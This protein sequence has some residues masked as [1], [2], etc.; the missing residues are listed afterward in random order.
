MVKNLPAMQEA[1]VWSLVRK[2]LWRREWLPTPVFLPGE[3]HGQR[4]LAGYSPWGCK[5]LDMAERLTLKPLTLTDGILAIHSFRKIYW[6]HCVPDTVLNTCKIWTKQCPSPQGAYNL[7]EKTNNKQTNKVMSAGEQKNKAEKRNV[8]KQEQELF[9]MSLLSEKTTTKKRPEWSERVG[10]AATRKKNP[11]ICAAGL[12]SNVI[13]NFHS[14]PRK[15]SA[16]LP[17]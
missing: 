2:I 7:K 15:M 5:E 13:E 16:E 17:F 14:A 12:W 3:F 9:Y 8:R 4:S 6:H 11:V 1:Q 10:Q